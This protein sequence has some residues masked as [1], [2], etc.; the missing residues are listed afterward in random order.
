[1]RTTVNDPR[2]RDASTSELETTLLFMQWEENDWFYRWE[3]MLGLVWTPEDLAILAEKPKQTGSMTP[4]QI[5]ESDA[6][7]VEST[8]I[9]R[10]PLSLLIR[11]ELLKNLQEHAMPATGGLFGMDHVPGDAASLYGSTKEE[12]LRRMGATSASK[13]DPD[14]APADPDAPSR[15]QAGGFMESKPRTISGARRK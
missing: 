14:W 9:L 6:R 12:F 5:A 2:L 15:R 1:M 13:D 7:E 11:P 8:G 3:R 4:E 10:Y